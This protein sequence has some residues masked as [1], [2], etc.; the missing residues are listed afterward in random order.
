MSGLRGVVSGVAA[1][2]LAVGLAAQERDFSKVEVTPAR[3]AEGVYMLTGAGGNLGL[4]VGES[5]AFLVDDQYAPL[6]PKIKA[7]VAGISPKPIRFVLNTHWHGD[8]TGGNENLG[9]E[10]VL[11][12][13]HDNVRKRMSVE[14]FNELFNSKTPAAPALALPVVTFG[15]DV[16]F[17]MNVDEIHAF[18]VPP[19]HTDGDAVVHFRKAN[20]VHMGDLYFNGMYPFVDIW[21]GG[22]FEGVIAAADKV[23]P[24]CDEQTKIIPGHGPVATKADLKGYRDTLAAIRDK[25][26]P[27]IASGRSLDEVKAAKPTAQWDEKLGQGF[28][29]PEMLVEIAYKSLSKK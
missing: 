19:A 3:L 5:G 22:S 10:G 27:L 17:H 29:K 1:A 12:V 18:H 13:A 21:S 14:Q 28:I 9:G 24:L 11:I 16:T 4:S 23:L 25:L 6:N 2:A 15:E 8:H 26:K 7:A 20:V